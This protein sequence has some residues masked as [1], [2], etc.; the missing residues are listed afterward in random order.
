MR[1]HRFVERGQGSGNFGRA[2]NAAADRASIGRA[3]ARVAAIVEMKRIQT[4]ERIRVG[5]PTGCGEA[6]GRLADD[7]A[8]DLEGVVDLMA[9]AVFAETI[10]VILPAHVIIAVHADFEARADQ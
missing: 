8:V 4:T 6:T 1:A 7:R 10:D 3:P 2:Q 5:A 9:D